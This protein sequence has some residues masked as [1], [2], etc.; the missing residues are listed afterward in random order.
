MTSEPQCP[1][2]LKY[3]AFYWGDA[4][5]GDITCHESP[6]TWV[7]ILRTHRKARCN[8]ISACAL[9]VSMGEWETQIWE[10]L[11]A[12]RPASLVYALLGD[13]VLKWK[14]KA[15]QP[16][17]VIWPLNSLSGHVGAPSHTWTLY[18][19]VTHTLAYHMHTVFKKWI[20]PF[21]IFGSP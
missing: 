20:A 2:F 3:E 18:T 6:M 15:W 19:H 9:S 8:S 12:Y 14:S 17:A 4:S 21:C 16:K 7:Q 1:H 5:V 10:P 13:L 11:D